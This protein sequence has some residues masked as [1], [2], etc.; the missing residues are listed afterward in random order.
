MRPQLIE[1]SLIARQQERIILWLAC[2]H[3]IS[4]GPIPKVGD[5]TTDGDITVG[6]TWSCRHCADPPVAGDPE[7]RREMLRRRI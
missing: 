1:R 5:F 2:G 6:G 4:I 3:K 7:S